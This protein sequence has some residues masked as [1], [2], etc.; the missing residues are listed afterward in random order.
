MVVTEE[1]V[2]VRRDG[3]RHYSRC[4]LACLFLAFSLLLGRAQSALAQDAMTVEWIEVQGRKVQRAEGVVLIGIRFDEDKRAAISV[5]QALIK[6][7]RLEIPAL[8]RVHLRSPNGN[9]VTL[10]PHTRFVVLELTTGESYSACE[11]SLFDVR[12]LLKFFNVSCK[13]SVAS[14]RGTKFW[15]RSNQEQITYVV[16]QGTVSISRDVYVSVRDRPGELIQTVNEESLSAGG[17][18]EASYRLDKKEIVKEF[19]SLSDSRKYFEKELAASLNS[20]SAAAVVSAALSLGKTLLLQGDA[21]GAKQKFELALNAARANRNRKAE[22]WAMNNLGVVAQELSALSESLAHHNQALKLRRSLYD[23]IHVE[24]AQSLN[25]LAIL[26]RALGNYCE[27]LRALEE[28]REIQR[29]LQTQDYDTKITSAKLALTLAAVHGETARFSA[30]LPLIDD[31]RKLL[32]ELRL[33][34]EVAVELANSDLATGIILREQGDLPEAIRYMQRA[35]AQY[36]QVL[37]TNDHPA[38]ANVEEEFGLTYSR[39]NE[40]KKGMELLEH[41]LAMWRRMIG[42]GEN[43]SVTFVLQH[44]GEAMERVGRH[45]DAERAYRQAA[46]IRRRLYGDSH[47][48]VAESLLGIARAQNALGNQAAALDDSMHTA[49]IL[50]KVYG[51]SHHPRLEE[52]LRLSGAILAAQGRTSESVQ[53]SQAL[54]QLQKV[55][56]EPLTCSAPN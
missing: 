26:N 21:K 55:R 30:A 28:A 52:A 27:A 22:A 41:A 20:N 37:G 8:T 51:K 15:V 48:L 24:I 3:A 19:R 1:A 2:A 9:Q 44:L 13:S 34:P 43:R 56:G 11:E 32:R 40:V 10:F 6:G 18:A 49:R 31:A 39:N 4:A 36:Q 14:V 53:I 45:G 46:E 47:P 33:T 17:R 25:N 12:K 23:P 42:N 16:D 7:I 54:A 50:R 38:V 5:S 35:Y 29:R